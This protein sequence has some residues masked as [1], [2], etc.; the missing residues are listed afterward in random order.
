MMNGAYAYD[1]FHGSKHTVA[2]AKARLC[3][4]AWFS[5][6]EMPVSSALMLYE[7]PDFRQLLPNRVVFGLSAQDTVEGQQA[8]DTV[9]L[10]VIMTL[11]TRSF[12]QH[13][14]RPIT[15]LHL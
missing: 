6:S 5:L 13:H 7:T 12:L 11:N 1:N 14:L 15:A 3:S 4:V 2:S 9:G 10:R 8:K